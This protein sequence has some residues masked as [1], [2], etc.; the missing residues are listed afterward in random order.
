MLIKKIQRRE[1]RIIVG[2]EKD[3]RKYKRAKEGNN[4]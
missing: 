2:R 3:E 1:K 4:R